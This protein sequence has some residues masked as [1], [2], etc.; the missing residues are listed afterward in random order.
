MKKSRISLD[1]IIIQ[2][3]TLYKAQIRPC[4][5]LASRVKAYNALID[6]K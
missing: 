3:H 4:L 2:L 1:N 5:W 6:E